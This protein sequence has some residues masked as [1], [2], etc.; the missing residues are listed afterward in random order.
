MAKK[1]SA[2]QA[3]AQIQEFAQQ[4]AAELAAERER[5][6]A[7]YNKLAHAKLSN[8]ALKKSLK[9]LQVRA[10]SELSSAPHLGMPSS[11]WL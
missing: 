1:V 8:A 7:T 2:E 3:T 11:S 9:A 5:H 6:S 10:L 4:L